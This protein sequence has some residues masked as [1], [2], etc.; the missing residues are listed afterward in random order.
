MSN[1]ITQKEAVLNA[2]SHVLGSSFTPG[3]TVVKEALSK[4]QLAEVRNIV[5]NGIVA[6]EVN[7]GQSTEDEKSLA[8]Y[9]NS[10]INNYFR[11]DTNLNG[12]E[13]YKPSKEGAPRDKQL[14]VLN[15]LLNSGKF[16]KGSDKYEKIINQIEFRK[17]ELADIRAARK[18]SA[19]IGTID[20]SVL[21]ADLQELA[22]ELTGYASDAE[23]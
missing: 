6:G 21:P 10:M 7:Y 13:S 17:T 16:P 1:S 18:A 2:V 22:S 5:F 20:T 3:E 8:A 19:S 9:V 4:E 11:R 14:K 23:V 12:G 15:Q